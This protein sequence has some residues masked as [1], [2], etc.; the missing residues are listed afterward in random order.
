MPVSRPFDAGFLDRLTGRII[1]VAKN[2]VDRHASATNNMRV[3]LIILI[4]Q[5]VSGRMF[6]TQPSAGSTI[7]FIDEFAHEIDSGN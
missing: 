4:R 7:G 6:S 2:D 5:D 3:T 1:Q